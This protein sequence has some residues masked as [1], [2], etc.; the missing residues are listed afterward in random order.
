MSH[1][2]NVGERIGFEFLAHEFADIAI[3]SLGACW[4]NNTAA[5]GHELRWMSTK[6]GG[7]L[8]LK[9]RFGGARVLWEE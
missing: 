6:F 9:D 8:D 3:A 4:L 2:S 1:H 5:F 7:H